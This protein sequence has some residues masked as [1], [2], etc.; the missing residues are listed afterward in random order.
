MIEDEETKEEVEEYNKKFNKWTFIHSYVKN[1]ILNMITTVGHGLRCV[2][3]GIIKSGD[4]IK[5][6]GLKEV[7]RC[8]NAAYDTWLLN[9]KNPNKLRHRNGLLTD[10]KF[11]I[12]IGFTIA[13]E[14]HVYEELFRDLYEEIG[15]S[16]AKHVLGLSDIKPIEL[17]K[18]KVK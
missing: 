8:V 12:N 2:P 5:S 15:M 17:N 7:Y 13:N 4:E 18:M 16:Y 1:M 9:G 11:L 3:N 10:A 14:D 6:T